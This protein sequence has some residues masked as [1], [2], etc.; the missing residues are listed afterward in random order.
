MIAETKPTL[1]ADPSQGL[2]FTL[3]TETPEIRRHLAC[4][5]PAAVRFEAGGFTE[6]Q[7]FK[8][9]AV[10]C[11]YHQESKVKPRLEKRERPPTPERVTGC[12]RRNGAALD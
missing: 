9:V 12:R 6:F 11:G 2:L 5:R 3:L 1:K 4:L 10:E 8:Y 7:S